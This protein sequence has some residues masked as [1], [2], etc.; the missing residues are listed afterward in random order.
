[1][2]DSI[3][4]VIAGMGVSAMAW[5]RWSKTDKAKQSKIKAEA[6]HEYAIGSKVKQEIESEIIT[7]WKDL[8]DRFQDDLKHSRESYRKMEH[9]Y[10]EVRKELQ[11]ERRECER[12]DRESNEKIFNLS[13]TIE[14]MRQKI[15]ILENR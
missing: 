3:W 4:G 6:Y 5:A 14:E 1:M 11:E 7:H 12:R 9:A 15:Q 10:F 8:L 13:Q 2:L